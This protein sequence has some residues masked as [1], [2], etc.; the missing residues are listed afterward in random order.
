MRSKRDPSQAVAWNRG[1]YLVEG[2][3]HCVACHTPKTTLGAEDYRQAFQGGTLD[4]LG[5][6]RPHRQSAHRDRP[7]ERAGP[8]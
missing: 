4:K 6:T 2:L 8:G 3:A 5:G 7:V 1:A